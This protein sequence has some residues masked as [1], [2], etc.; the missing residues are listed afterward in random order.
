MPNYREVCNILFTLNTH[1]SL[2]AFQTSLK[3]S[4]AMAASNY[5]MDYFS[6]VKSATSFLMSD[7]LPYLQQFHMTLI[8]IPSFRK[9]V[10]ILSAMTCKACNF[11]LHPGCAL[12]PRTTR[13]RWDKHPLTLSYPPFS[14]HP[15]EFYREICELEIHPKFW[16]YHCRECDYSFHPRCILQ[17]DEYSNIKFGGTFKVNNPLILS[18]LFTPMKPSPHVIIVEKA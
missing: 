17:L 5:R 13:H 7:V 3:F 11:H 18:L 16:L 9:E 4:S 8:A 2:E 6:N 12:L 14:Y 10:S 1:F 15:D